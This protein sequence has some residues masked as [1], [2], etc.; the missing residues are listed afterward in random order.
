MS[1]MRGRGRGAGRRREVDAVH[2][3]APSIP[4]GERDDHPA[5]LGL[6]PAGGRAAGAGLARAGALALALVALVGFLV[7]PT[8]P[9]LRL[10]LLAAVGP[11]AAARHHAVA[12]TSTARR[13]SIRSRVAFGAL[14]SLLGDARRPRHGLRDA[15]VVRRA[16]RRHVPAGRAAF[17]PLVGADRGARC[18]CTRFDFPF[19]AARGYIDI[20]YLAL[21]VWAAALEVRAPAARHRR[22]ACCW[23]APASAAGGVAAGR[24]VLA[25]VHRRPR[26][27]WPQRVLY[28]GAHR[29]GPVIWALTDL[30]VDRPSDV[31]ADAHERPGGGARA[32]SAG[33]EMPSATVEFL[34]KL[35][36][37]PVLY[38]GRRSGCCS[39]SARPAAGRIPLALLVIGLGTFVLVGWPGCRSSTA[40]CW[41]RR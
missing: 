38:A 23:P 11:G 32:T 17:G 37:V 18:C 27:S 30:V 16:R 33:C 14:L 3:L 26:A 28:A 20:P 6:D 15:G 12:S 21:V 24:P 19:L 4:H 7:Y 10:V 8:Y 13:P 1:F 41:C 34:K 35:D 40:T 22:S 29:P 2:S 5:G 25:L 36:K 9:E 39:R 31:L